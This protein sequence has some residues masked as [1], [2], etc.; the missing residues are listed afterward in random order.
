MRGQRGEA[1]D[2]DTYLQH[3]KKFREMTDSREAAD[4]DF[5]KTFVDVNSSSSKRSKMTEQE[6]IIEQYRQPKPP[7]KPTSAPPGSFQRL[8]VYHQRYVRGEA[9]FHPNDARLEGVVS[10]S[11][12]RVTYSGYSKRSTIK[13][14]C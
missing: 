3:V 10:S 13:K 9:I 5:I 1:T 4:H 8:M 14:F 7:R 2:C 11:F 12:E 6:R